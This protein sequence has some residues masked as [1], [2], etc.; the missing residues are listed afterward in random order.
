MSRNNYNGIRNNI[1]GFVKLNQ[2]MDGKSEVYLLHPI[3]D[4]KLQKYEIQKYRIN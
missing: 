4:S 2:D 3:I 1:Q